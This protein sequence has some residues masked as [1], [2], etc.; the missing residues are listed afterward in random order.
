[1][2]EQRIREHQKTLEKDLEDAGPIEHKKDKVLKSLD[3]RAFLDVL[4]GPSKS[5][6]VSNLIPKEFEDFSCARDLECVVI[7]GRG[8][9]V[10]LC[11]ASLMGKTLLSGIVFAQITHHTRQNQSAL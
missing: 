6:P 9:R 11:A 8:G 5:Q 3:K 1:M 2:F 4:M 7:G 10:A